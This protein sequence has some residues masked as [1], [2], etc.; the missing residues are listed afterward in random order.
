M[1]EILIC[2]VIILPMP[3]SWRRVILETQAKAWNKYPR[4]RFTVK[5]IMI[6]IL[7]FSLDAAWSIYR[8]YLVTNLPPHDTEIIGQPG[9]Q[10]T[11]KLYEAERNLCL[12]LFILFLFMLIYR[13][14]SMV[15]QAVSLANE[16]EINTEK[17]AKQDLEHARLMKERERWL[18]GEYAPVGQS[19]D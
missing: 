2:N 12:G 8:A 1:A 14:Q 9:R 7:G 10:V 15:H 6:S 4:F 13:F 11:M 17:S 5:T 18:S 3:S 19:T 16:L